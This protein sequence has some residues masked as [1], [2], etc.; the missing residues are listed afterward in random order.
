MTVNGKPLEM[1]VVTGA[2]ISLISKETLE[3][4]SASPH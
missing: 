2:A 1:E 3:A 4:M